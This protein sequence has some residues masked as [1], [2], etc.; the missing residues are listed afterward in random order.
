M[1]YLAFLS[2]RTRILMLVLLALVPALGLG[3]YSATTQRRL[4]TESIW[5]DMR[6]TVHSIEAEHQQWIAGASLLVQVIAQLPAVREHDGAACSAFVAGLLRR[7]RFY[8]NIAAVKP[9]GDVFCSAAP[10]PGPINTAQQPYFL[11]ALRTRDVTVAAYAHGHAHGRISRKSVL[12]I[13]YPLFDSAG[14]LQTVVYVALDLAW[15]NRELGALRLPKAAVLTVLDREGTILARSAAPE[16]W[17]GKSMPETAILGLIQTQRDLTMTEVLVEAKPHLVAFTPLAGGPEGP[18]AFIS[19]DVPKAIAFAEVNRNLT[20]YALT[21]AFACVL[22]LV[23]AWLGG[24]LVMRREEALRAVEQKFQAVVQSAG[25]AIVSADSRGSMI[26][27]NRGA[28]RI[29]GYTVAEVLGQPLTLLMPEGYREAH[30]Q[31]LERLRST[32]EARVLG[33]SVELAGRRKD[34]SEFPLELSLAQWSV[35]GETFYSGVLR[36][37]T[38]RKQADQMKSDFVSFATHQLRTPL[39]GI[40]WLLELAAQETDS[41]EDALSYIVDAQAS[42]DRLIHL[43]NDLLDVSRLESGRLAIT[44]QATRLDELT[45]DVLDEMGLLIRE[46]GHQ[47]SVHGMENLPPVVVDPQLLRQVILNLVSNAIK[48]TPAP[49]GIVIRMGE[50]NGQVCWAIQDS[51]IGI[52]HAAQRWLFEKFYRAE[53]VLTIETEGTGLGLYLVRLIMERFGGRV[54]CESEE[55]KGTTFLFTLPPHSETQGGKGR[56]DGSVGKTDSSGGR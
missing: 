33:K 20:Y 26:A 39:A 13:A 42:A 8:A 32:G 49:G 4:A 11:Q 19:L 12:P 50:T 43:V 40:K 7:F 15:F 41:P 34:G 45:Q 38:E 10:L 31:G 29:F 52:P 5:N 22:V 48:Y 24:T 51:G 27:W 47:L 54:W 36:D 6:D 53:N 46:K 1:R 25:E 18:A 17:M 30:L 56:C 55:G 35:G 37:I 16:Q 21:L 9:N 28:E 23:V 14:A 2:L 3:L 44:P